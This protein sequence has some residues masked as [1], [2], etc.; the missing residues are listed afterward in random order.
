VCIGDKP[1]SEML[2]GIGNALDRPFWEL[3]CA[4]LDGDGKPELIG[5]DVDGIVTVRH[6]GGAPRL[7]FDAG[8]LVYQFAAADLDGDGVQEIIYSSVDPKIAVRGVN[9]KGATVRTFAEVRGPERLAVGDLDGDGQPEIAVSVDHQRAGSGIAA[10]VAVYDRGGRK[11]WAKERMVRTFAFGDWVRGGGQELIVGGSNVEFTV[12]GAKGEELQRFAAQSALL[13]QFEVIDIDGD[14]SP[15][16]VALYSAGPRFGLLCHNGTRQ[17]WD[18][19]VTTSPKNSGTGASALIACGEFD[20]KTP[21]RETVVMSLHVVTVVDASGVLVYQGRSGGEGEYWQMWAPG[22]INS[23]D[24]AYFAG[25]EPALYLSSS[26]F[27]HPAYYR[28][29]YGRPDELAAFKV[30]DQEQHLE[31]LHATVRAQP[32]RPAQSAAKVKVFMAQSEFARVPEATLREY[33]AALRKLETPALEYLVM[34]EASDLLGHERG[35]KMT[36]DQIVER[37]RLFEQVGIPFGYFATHG[38]QVWITRE[39]IR[40]S[41]E[42]APKMFRFLYIAENLETLYGPLYRDVLKWTDEALDFCA[43]HGMKMIFREK[44]DVWGLL[45]SDPEVFN[46]LFSPKHRDVTVPIWS[47]NQ[48]YQPEIQLGGMLGLQAAGL[49]REFGMST[50]YWNWHEWGRY[51]RGIR[52]I[53]PTYVCPSDIILRLELMGVALGGTWVHVEGGQTYLR[54]DPRQGVVPLANRHRELVYEVVR[55]N[56]LS[57]GALP[58]NLNAATLVRSFHPALEEG[59]ARGRKVAYPYYE[60][61]SDALR[62]GFIPARY[63]FEPY[64]EDAFPR[65]AYHE[66]WNVRSCF[67]RTPF[68][69]VPVLPPTAELRPGAPAIHTD[70]ER[71][72]LAGQWQSAAT[73]ANGVAEVLTRGA[74]GIPLAAPG[75]CLILQRDRQA[76]GRYV[77]VLIDPGYL[78]PTGVDTTLTARSGSIR[79][80]T[81]VVS[82]REIPVKADGCPIRIEPGAFRLLQVVMEE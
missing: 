33:A 46:V 51:P 7:R 68:G 35:Q 4:D 65:I 9:L 28:I 2:T 34:Y 80:I 81:D 17:L 31:A 20:P 62:Q 64:A 38:G 5:C 74:A 71:V 61:N 22:G 72:R 40:R 14:Q 57:P 70:G 26:R 52:D 55:K 67:P 18:T 56:L 82:G 37:A 3:F 30:P 29:D 25:R 49:C 10:G 59:K 42:V 27:R 54:S 50:Q 48:P 44:H 15:E 60:R 58:A 41:K 19:P 13:E 76:G 21:G 69:W 24:L 12:H 63:L 66:D 77:A 16:I 1:E 45:P 32:A 8:A 39:A 79:R 75:T 11:L 53:S 36:T 43:E 6:E 23:P 78:A 73:A 47:T